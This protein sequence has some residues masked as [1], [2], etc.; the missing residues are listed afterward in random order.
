M[1]FMASILKPN[2]HVNNRVS[3]W[4]LLYQYLWPY[5]MFM[6]ANR[7]SPCERTMAYRHNREQRVYLPGYILKWSCI[8]FLLFCLTTVLGA[9]DIDFP[10][11]HPVYVLVAVTGILLTGALIVTVLICVTYLM[12]WRNEE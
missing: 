1:T 3:A 5:W 11:F 6:D 2:A 7:G 10:N 12:L 4:R 8:S 9:K